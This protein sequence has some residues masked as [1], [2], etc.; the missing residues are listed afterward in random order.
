MSF[1]DGPFKI[2]K[3]INDNVYKLELPS[4]FGVSHTF[5]ISDL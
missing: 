5:D 2:I 1:D 4:D 3:R